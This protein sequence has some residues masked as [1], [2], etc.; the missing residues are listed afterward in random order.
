M[1]C[2]VLADGIFK[3][4]IDKHRPYGALSPA[5]FDMARLD[6]TDALAPISASVKAYKQ[7]RGDDEGELGDDAIASIWSRDAGTYYCNEALY[8][9]SSTIRKLRVTHPRA[10]SLLLPFAFVHLP[11]PKAAP[12]ATVV[13]PAIAE[14]A[15]ALLVDVIK[16]ERRA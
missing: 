5:T 7:S 16:A 3:Q 11:S 10:P 14:L 4:R 2:D 13:A 1:C 12:V 15:K 6:V 8:R 9:S